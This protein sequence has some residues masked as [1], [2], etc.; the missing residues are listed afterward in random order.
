MPKLPPLRYCYLSRTHY[1]H[2]G[3][4]Q[5]QLVRQHLNYKAALSAY[6]PP[7]SP[8]TSNHE[9]LC[10]SDSPPPPTLFLFQSAP[11]A[12]VCGRREVDQMTPEQ[13]DHLTHEGAEFYESQRGG[14]TTF[15]G[16]GQ[17]T[18]YLVCDLKRH[19]L[20]PRTL[21]RTLER[22]A[23]NV[24]GM[25]GLPTH[26]LDDYPGVWRK[27]KDKVSS[28]VLKVGEIRESNKPEFN[29]DGTDQHSNTLDAK[30]SQVKDNVSSESSDNGPGSEYRK[31]ASVG[32]H[33]RRNVSSYG[34][35]INVKTDLSYFHRM[36]ACGL[37]GTI[38][39]NMA[40]EGGWRGDAKSR[41]RLRGNPKQL[42]VRL[43][44]RDY[45]KQLAHM[46][47]GVSGVYNVQEDA[48]WDKSQEMRTWERRLKK[49]KPGASADLPYPSGSTLRRP[50][51]KAYCD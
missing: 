17:A 14:Q 11:G 8:D 28:E 46:L 47:H 31:L 39:T 27:A 13:I 3:V 50:S 18:F 49:N 48:L 41:F 2:A 30:T 5:E 25:Y 32:V 44:G 37:P 43:V 7:P 35:G 4:L 19:N 36:T 40:E 20:T 42:K 12:Y 15:H 22:A 24:F 10:Q 34:I 45:A 6:N 9:S 23:Q 1:L 16:I 26:L 33:L 29:E 21:I 51:K 38:I